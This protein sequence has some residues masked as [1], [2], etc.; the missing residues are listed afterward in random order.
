MHLIKKSNL[1]I[2]VYCRNYVSI[3]P[4][5]NIVLKKLNLFSQLFKR[6]VVHVHIVRHHKNKMILFVIRYVQF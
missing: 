3:F 6:K 1:D 2:K 4:I 5:A